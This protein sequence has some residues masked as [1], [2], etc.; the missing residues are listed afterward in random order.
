MLL[1]VVLTIAVLFVASMRGVSALPPPN[2]I[3]AASS[4]NAAPNGTVDIAVPVQLS[5]IPS[6]FKS[7]SVQCSFR[8]VAGGKGNGTEFARVDTPLGSGGDFSGTIHATLKID[9]S[10][11]SSINGYQCDLYLFSNTGGVKPG[12]AASDPQAQ[13]RAGTTFVGHVEGGF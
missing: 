1:R 10:A 7:F 12:P 4:G 8:Y 5:Q 13:P 3:P 9:S 6:S 11:P 2:Q